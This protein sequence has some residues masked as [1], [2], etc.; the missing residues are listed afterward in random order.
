MTQIVRIASGPSGLMTGG[1][2]V[3]DAS[4]D[5]YFYSFTKAQ[6]DARAVNTDPTTDAYFEAMTD[7]LSEIGWTLFKAKPVSQNVKDT[8]QIP[9]IVCVMAL[10]D[11]AQD[12]VGSVLP[13]DRTGLQSKA[14]DLC[15]ALRNPPAPVAQQLDDWWQGAEISADYRVMSIGPILEILGVPNLMAM[16]LSL[17]FA[18]NSWRSFVSPSTDFSISARPALMSLNWLKYKLQEASLKA[19]LA[20]ELSGKIKTADLSFGQ[21]EAV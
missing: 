14:N 16:H 2:G 15:A 7:S 5:A 13:I 10:L 18:A 21:T 8:P 3:S 17:H 12:G 1:E 11:M 19:S 20:Q 6:M 4:L 9:L